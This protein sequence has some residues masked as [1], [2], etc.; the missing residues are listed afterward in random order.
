MYRKRSMF[1]RITVS[2]LKYLWNRSCCKTALFFGGPSAKAPH[3]SRH[4]NFSLSLKFGL[5]FKVGLC[6]RGGDEVGG[7][8]VWAQAQALASSCGG[9]HLKVPWV[10][11]VDIL[12][13]GG[14]ASR[15]M[16]PG[17]ICQPSICCSV[18]EALCTV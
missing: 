17:M 12:T 7:R 5:H 8:P 13:E 4:S 16:G 18:V 3:T 1:L 2:H 11:V 10:S 14:E 6:A 15:S 9:R